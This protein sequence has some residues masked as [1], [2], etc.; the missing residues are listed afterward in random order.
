MYS[1]TKKANKGSKRPQM[2]TSVDY[3]RGPTFNKRT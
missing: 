1:F 2:L 3:E